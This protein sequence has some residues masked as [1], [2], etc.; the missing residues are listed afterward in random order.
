[1]LAWAWPKLTCFVFFFQLLADNR[2]ALW[3]SVTL[4]VLP[5]QFV[6]SSWIFSSFPL[7]WPSF[8]ASLE[9][10]RYAHRVVKQGGLGESP[11][12]NCT[13]LAI[14]FHSCL[15][16][17]S[18][19]LRN[20]D[21]EKERMRKRYSLAAVLQCGMGAGPLMLPEWVSAPPIPVFNSCS[22]IPKLWILEFA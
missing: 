9:G 16:P 1:M 10:K 7:Y 6:Y 20:L 12:N 3:L 5:L 11:P 2:P 14:L 22:R 8:S 18:T 4:W 15:L 13:E 21:R 19:S 17:G